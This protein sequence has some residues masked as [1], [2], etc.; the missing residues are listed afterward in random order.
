MKAKKP[1]I[2]KAQ[3]K[4][5]IEELKASSPMSYYLANNDMTD[6]LEYRNIGSGILV[7]LQYPGGK[8]VVAPFMVVDGFMQQTVDSLRREILKSYRKI[9]ELKPKDIDA[10]AKEGE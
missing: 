7:T 1:K 2:T 3:L 9:T 8:H 5:K 4:Q 10:P 6:A